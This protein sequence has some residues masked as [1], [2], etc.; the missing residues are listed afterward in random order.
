MEASVIIPAYN[1]EKNIENVIERVKR[2][3]N[4]EIIIVDDGSSDKTAEIALK[5]GVK[6]ISQKQNKGKASACIKGVE[7]AKSSKIVFIDADMQLKPE[8]IP[9]FVKALD[10][11][12]LAI[13]V[14]DM[15][16]IPFQRRLSNIVARYFVKMKTGQKFSDVLCGFRGIRNDKI[17]KMK[18]SGKGYEFETEMIFEAVKNKMKIKEVPVSVNYESYRG[19]SIINSIKLLIFIIKQKKIVIS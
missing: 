19:M 16:K 1:E 6:V 3:G 5:K 8:E 9:L 13:G 12:D 17:K 7:N 2:T 4:Y 18:F 14:R 11:C 10:S 15:K